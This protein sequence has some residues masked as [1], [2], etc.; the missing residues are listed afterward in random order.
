MDVPT[1]LLRL[2]DELQSELIDHI[3]PYWMKVGVDRV[4]GGFAGHV[5]ED[6]RVVDGAPKGAILNARILWT[7]SAAFRHA[8]GDAYLA[9]A[10]RAYAYI[11]D[12]FVD[13]EEGG[14]FWMVDPEGRPLDDRKHVY[15]QA[16]ALYAFS[17]FYMASRNINSLNRAVELFELIEERAHDDVNRGYH[18][19]FSRDWQL[20][21]DV[22]LSDKDADERRSMNTH[23]HLLEAYTNL[24]RNWPN[25]RL[26]TR[27]RELIDLFLTTIIDPET[28]HLITFF[29]DEWQPKST[30]I[31][32]GH[33]IESTWLLLEAADVLVD[34]ALRQEVRA[35]ALATARAVL[36]V[37]LDDDGGLL[38]EAG[39]NGLIDGDK[40]WWPQAEA[41]VG[42]VVAY[43][44]SG[45]LAF[46]D[47]ALRVW[48][49]TQHCI[50]DRDHGE[51]FMRTRRDGRRYEG[52]EKIGPWKCPYHNARACM[53]VVRRVDVTPDM[54]P[55]PRNG[56]SAAEA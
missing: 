46:L 20:L 6:N 15:A 13:D 39:P 45:E 51:W 8:G 48:S 30:E 44:E 12:F 21:Q 31:S 2:R 18:E 5:A 11:L 1:D 22:R 32:F 54:L 34:P 23:L 26:E 36:N 3:L 4:N 50:I 55:T 56:R 7:F 41:I 43:Q 47:A 9:M 42:F 19:A 27:L 29:D 33:D 17:E 14:V 37:G 35:R 49:F 40:H 10:E 25:P 16:F 52:E 28:S 38:Y 53:E 24:Y